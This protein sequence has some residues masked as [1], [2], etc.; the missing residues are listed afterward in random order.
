ML[1]ADA[2][3][4]QLA[5]PVWDADLAGADSVL[6]RA[7]PAGGAPV[8]VLVTLPSPGSGSYYLPS[9]AGDAQDIL[10]VWADAIE[11][12]FAL[13]GLS[14]T[15]SVTWDQWSGQGAPGY[16]T[17]AQ[18]A[19]DT[20]DAFALLWTD[21]SSTLTE[22]PRGRWA[23]SRLLGFSGDQDT[24]ATLSGAG[25]ASWQVEHQP[26]RLWLPMR[27][28]QRLE[29]WRTWE[30]L[31]LERPFDGA[32]V[33]QTY[34]QPQG[35]RRWQLDLD[36][37]PAVRCRTSAAEQAHFRAAA[38]PMGAA[39]TGMALEGWWA[40]GLLVGGPW[41]LWTDWRQVADPAARQLVGPAGGDGKLGDVR[42]LLTERLTSPQRYRVQLSLLEWVDL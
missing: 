27:L 1:I 34:S 6:I 24:T 11:A 35:V 10:R 21:A 42:T 8:D 29:D 7:T 30:T 19:G 4:P 16:A 5:L 18:T 22:V 23:A 38:A 32:V 12:A 17:F 15:L 41:V 36:H 2:P 33:W 40:E 20:W 3:F 39:D 31:A 37:V 25:R 26:H 9:R 13:A 14:L 28:P